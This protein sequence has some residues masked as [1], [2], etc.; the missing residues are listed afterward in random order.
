VGGLSE[1]NDWNVWN[2]L[3]MVQRFKVEKEAGKIGTQKDAAI[4]E[5]R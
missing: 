3:S 1:W 5:S 4:T 2:Y